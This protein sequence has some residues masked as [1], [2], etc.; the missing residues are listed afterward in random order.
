MRKMCGQL[1]QQQK[2]INE[3]WKKVFHFRWH[4]ERKFQNALFQ[5]KFLN[6]L[7]QFFLASTTNNV[8]HLYY[9]LYVLWYAIDK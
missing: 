4:K 9:K 5:V 2:E 7:R 1:E 8:Q 3:K 6:Y